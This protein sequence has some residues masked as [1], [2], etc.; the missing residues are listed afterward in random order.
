MALTTKWVRYTHD[1]AQQTKLGFYKAEYAFDDEGRLWRRTHARKPARRSWGA[2]AFWTVVTPWHLDDP[3]QWFPDEELQPPTGSRV[4]NTRAL[5]PK[6]IDR[7][8]TTEGLL[9]VAKETPP[10]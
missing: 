7:Y 5:L 4:A 9:V 1:P 2:S 6:R 10:S 8:Q 3:Y